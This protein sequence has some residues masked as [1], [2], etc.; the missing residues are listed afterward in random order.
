MRDFLKGVEDARLRRTL[1]YSLFDGAM[2]SIMYG[3]A[4]NYMTPFVLFFGASVFQVSLMQ[5]LAQLATGGGQ[6]LGGF[7][8]HR[9][10]V[11]RRGLSSATVVI[12]AVS[13]F[14][15]FISAY[16]TGSPLGAILFYCLGTF[17]TNIGSPGWNSWMNDLVP[18][19][20]RGA[21]WSRRNGL[22]GFVQFVAITAAGLS[23]NMAKKSG[24]EALCFGILF[25]L[26]FAFR[27]GSVYFLAKQHHPRFEPER[28]G[29]SLNL[30]RFLAELPRSSFGRFVIFI[31]LTN[32]TV[33]MV[34]PIVQVYLLESLRLDYVQYTIVTMTASI[35]AFVFMTYWGGLSDRFGNRRILIV[36]SVGLPIVALAWVF[37]RPTWAL[38]LLQLVTGFVT[39]GFNLATTNYI[40]DATPPKTLPKI[41]AYF[42]TL[43]MG[44]GF[45]GSLFSGL[46]AALVTS[47]G[48]GLGW[49]DAYLMV[50]AL[51]ALMRLAI[52]LLFAGRI[53]EVRDAEASPGISYFYLYKPFQD[54]AGFIYR[55]GTGIRG[56]GRKKP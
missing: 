21:F 47:R 15:I 30:L 3:L 4:E 56:M 55:T 8:V 20:K 31:M 36:T 24:R 17:F 12:H 33:L 53:K 7:I 54:V 1:I 48:W 50:F 26:A 9:G 44:A 5:G 49:F 46:M 18:E 41:M 34:N 32:F 42:N 2:W 39:S 35:G 23:L 37:V 45:L 6:L 22:L 25:V 19:K 51:A 16:L 11:S 13:W 29:T 27:M 28:S 38:V 52:L 40:F 43:N 10:R 14:L